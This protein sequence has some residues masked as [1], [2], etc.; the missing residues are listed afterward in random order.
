MRRRDVTRAAA[1]TSAVLLLSA[2]GD[3]GSPDPQPTGSDGETVSS[4]VVG[5]GPTDQSR[6]VAQVWALAL[7]DAGVQVEVREVD[8]GR[9]GYLQAVQDGEIDVY[10]D[11]TGDLYLQLRGTESSTPSPTQEATASANPGS[12]V[13]SLANLLGQ[14]QQ[15]VTDN[16]VESA[17]AE[18][19]PTG[20]QMLNPA[21]AEN[22]RILAVTSATQA[23]LSV[24]SLSELSQYCSDLTFGALVGEDQ[25]AVTAAAV[26]QTYS[27]TPKDVK[28]FASQEEVTQALLDGQIDVAG[29]L[30]ATP[31]VG[32]NSLKALDDNRDALVP[33]RVIPIADQN[34]PDAAGQEINGISSDLDTDAL[35]LLTRMTT[36][37]TPYSPEDAAA[38]WYGTVRP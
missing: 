30:S 32:D 14:G 22:K 13:D 19:L 15:G 21:P 8:G 9:A 4:V 12:F 33:E 3:S 17:L 29:L 20:V 24:N 16:D 5:V 10:P 27:C 7:E 11:Y 37:S 31:E 28:D 38:Y 2:C 25:A 6:T 35:I 1:L 18:Q 34:L 26:E 36:A 23:K